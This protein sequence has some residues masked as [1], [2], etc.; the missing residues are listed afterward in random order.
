MNYLFWTDS[1]DS[2]SLIQG[3]YN[4][5][6]CIIR[7]MS[8]LM[9]WL[10]GVI[11]L[12]II[13]VRNHQTNQRSFFLQN[14]DSFNLAHAELDQNW[15]SDSRILFFSLKAGIFWYYQS[16]SKL[17]NFFVLLIDI[18]FFLAWK[19]AREITKGLK[20]INSISGLLAC[21]WETD[22]LSNAF[23]TRHFFGKMTLKN[24]ITLTT[25]RVITEC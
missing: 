8:I 6:F 4:G 9:D 10:R 19:S 12:K 2:V 5:R 17:W 15:S 18:T 3:R 14:F 22:G 16:K 24:H 7:K 21:F 13:E 20:D 11:V 25:L 23:Q 1:S